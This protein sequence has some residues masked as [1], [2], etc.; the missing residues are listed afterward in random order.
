MHTVGILTIG[1]Y[2][3]ETG[4]VRTG[5]FYCLLNS[6]L[7]LKNFETRKGNTCSTCYKFQQVEHTVKIKFPSYLNSYYQLPIY[8]VR[9]IP[10][11]LKD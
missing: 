1:T 4:I 7:Y 6:Y 5:G 3:M 10:C 2:E 8:P 11:T 9:S